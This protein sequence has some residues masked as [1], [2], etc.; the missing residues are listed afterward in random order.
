MVFRSL[1]GVDDLDPDLDAFEV[2]ECVGLACNTV[3]GL[4]RGEPW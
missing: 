1:A 4:V 2:T 3:T